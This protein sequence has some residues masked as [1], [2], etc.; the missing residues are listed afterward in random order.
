MMSGGKVAGTIEKPVV[1]PSVPV[2]ATGSVARTDGAK[3][4]PAPA[5]PSSDYKAGNREFG[6]FHVAGSLRAGL[7]GGNFPNSVE[8]NAQSFVQDLC[9]K[10]FPE[11]CVALANLVKDCERNA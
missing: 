4:K 6:K 1:K 2:G 8:A 7:A 3:A 9:S 5:A 10:S 11:Q